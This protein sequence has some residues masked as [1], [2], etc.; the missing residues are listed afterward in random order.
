MAKANGARKRHDPQST[1]PDGYRQYDKL[2]RRDTGRHYVLVNPND[3]IAGVTAYE[4]DGYRLETKTEDGVRPVFGVAKDGVWQ[5]MGQVLM[6]CPVEDYEARMASGQSLSDRID[7]RMLK[8]GNLE[9]DG[10][11]GRGYTVGVNT[12][13]GHADERMSAPFVEEGV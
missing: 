4:A 13:L 1:A 10:F 7:E 6:S 9:K 12:S 2:L 3:Q 11:R 5:V 8:R